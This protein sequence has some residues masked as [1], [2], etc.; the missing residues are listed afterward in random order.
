MH[1]TVSSL[2]VVKLLTFEGKERQ[3]SK[4]ILV[5]NIRHRMTF[6]AT[7]TDT[8]LLEKRRD[9]LW[10]G[11]L[12][13]SEMSYVKVLKLR[14]AKRE[15]GKFELEMDV[16]RLMIRC[17]N[18]I[19]TNSN[20]LILM[21]FDTAGIKQVEPQCQRITRSNWSWKCSVLER[22][23]EHTSKHVCLSLHYVVVCRYIPC[24][25]WNVLKMNREKYY[26][27]I[28]C[29]VCTQLLRKAFPSTNVTTLLARGIF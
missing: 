2:Q 17:E 11:D 13:G 9:S 25:W 18:Y 22:N 3:Y 24:G 21:R 19:A 10:E 26:I 15:Q 1:K 12:L 27:L 14:V 4:H 20:Q 5:C 28:L 23:L 29:E 6:H 7:M 16:Y 8:P